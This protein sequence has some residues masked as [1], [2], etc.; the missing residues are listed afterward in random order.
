MSPIG[1]KVDTTLILTN[2]PVVL[3]GLYRRIKCFFSH[4]HRDFI[5]ITDNHKLIL[6]SKEIKM[7]I[8]LKKINSNFWFDVKCICVVCCQINK[9]YQYL[10][11]VF[12][13]TYFYV[14]YLP[15][16]KI[17]SSYLF[18]MLCVLEIACSVTAYVMNNKLYTNEW[19][20]N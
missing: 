14:Q 6:T 18:K 11:F 15:E 20:I 10:N 9:C 19:I 8:H 1:V 3:N 17:C 2:R 13:I 12:H 5:A 4:I 16:T 7:K